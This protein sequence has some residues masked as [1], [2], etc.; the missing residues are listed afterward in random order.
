MQGVKPED[1]QQAEQAGKQ[2]EVEYDVKET[3]QHKSIAGYDAH[4]VVATIT[5]HEKGQKI[6]DSGGMILTSDI[7]LGPKIAALDEIRDFQ[8]KY[9]KAV[10]GEAFGVDMQQ[11][12]QMMAM[13]PS[14]KEMMARMQAESGKMQGTPLTNSTMF[15]TVRAR[16]R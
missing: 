14:M 15:D 10:Y 5:M 8:I 4:E 7:W 9:F 2:M 1:K 16:T 11:M 6:E 12:S 13:Y 3:G